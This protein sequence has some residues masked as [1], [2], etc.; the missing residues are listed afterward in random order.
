LSAERGQSG[1]RARA[2]VSITSRALW[3]I[4]LAR[5]LPR[6]AVLAAA[7]AGLAASARF[8][9]APPHA[10]P[11]RSALPALAPRDPAAEGF[12]T[13]FARR[14]LS[15]SASEPLSS[16]RALERFLGAGLEADAGLT[17]PQ[18]GEQR[19]EWAEV[20][21]ERSEGVGEHVYTVAAQ[22]DTAGVV[23]LSLSVAHPSA[24]ALQLAG[25]PAIVGA[26][27]SA[28]ASPPQHLGEVEEPALATVAQRALR[29][30]L[31][32]SPSELAA[33]LTRGARV[34]PPSLGLSLE[35]V[36]RLDWGADGR[37]LLAVVRAADGRGVHYTLAYQLEVVRDQGRWEVA[38]VQTD[39]SS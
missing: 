32:D 10:T 36:Q 5:E 1:S 23:Y 3:R 13:L 21:Q 9:V 17:L 16:S 15:W 24:G 30:Y 19:V 6:Y 11:A 4:R 25:Y 33:D 38:A 28:A 20:V 27:S 39:P 22:T 2:S 29:N 14:Y 34:S 31:A 18:S 8:A 37:S 12:A 7:V 26:P 35:S